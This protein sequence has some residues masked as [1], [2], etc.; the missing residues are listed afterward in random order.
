[1]NSDN[2]N[3]TL[4]TQFMTKKC[5]VSVVVVYASVEPTDGDSSD[6]IGFYLQLQEQ[7]DRVPSRIVVFY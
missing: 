3:R 4:I 6:S 1:M 7:I 5:R 2:L